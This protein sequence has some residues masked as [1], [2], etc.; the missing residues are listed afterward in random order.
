MRRR[1]WAGTAAARRGARE[2][3]ATRRLPGRLV[4]ERPAADRL[5]PSRA[6]SEGPSRGRVAK[7]AFWKSEAQEGAGGGAGVQPSGYGVHPEWFGQMP[8]LSSSYC[9]PE[10][11]SPADPVPSATVLRSLNGFFGSAESTYG[12]YG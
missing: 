11:P 9:Q 10:L 1:D 4:L 3:A 7:G 6:Q 2:P 8:P 12:P 5:R